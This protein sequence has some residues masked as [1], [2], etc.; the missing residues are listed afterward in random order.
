MAPQNNEEIRL[1]HLRVKIF[2]DVS[3]EKV[4]GCLENYLWEAEI[5]AEDYIS[6]TIHDHGHRFQFVL[7]YRQPILDKDDEEELEISEE[8]VDDHSLPF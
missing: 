8:I 2:T 5:A 3:P 6:H 7:I 4:A 1:G